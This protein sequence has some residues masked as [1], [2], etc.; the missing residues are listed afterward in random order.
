VSQE[1]PES[2][3]EAVVAG[4]FAEVL[5]LPAVGRNDSFFDLG[6]HSLLATQLVKRI[7]E[8]FRC[9][10]GVPLLFEAPTVAGLTSRLL[11]GAGPTGQ[12]LSGV[13]PLR[14]GTGVPLFCIHPGEGMSWCYAGL[15]QYLDGSVP[16]YG[17]QARGLT[18]DEDLPASLE[19]A[20]AEYVRHIRAVQPEGPYFLLGW[21][22]GGV[23]AQA[24]ATRLQAD[25]QEIGL[26]ALLDAYP[27]NQVVAR[28]LSRAE[29]ISLA[30]DGLDVPDSADLSPADLQPRLAERGSALGDL[31]EQALADVLRVTENNIQLLLGFEPDS[32]DG[33]AL[34]FQAARDGE[35]DERAKLWQAYIT[36]EIAVHLVDSTHF[37]MTSPE[38]LSAIGP[39]VATAIQE[40]RN[41]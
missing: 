33:N 11:Q 18:G 32:Y 16:V 41:R 35:N 13:L 12:S 25:E 28:E 38:A 36:G 37:H 3:Q 15:L 2:P 1:K 24:V 9:E 5:G 19:E 23:V 30:F 4:L 14:E 29:I 27:A 8:T 31:S 40:Y 17:I 7:G 22:Y 21:S 20:A 34:L 26:L 6:G 10:L 39:I